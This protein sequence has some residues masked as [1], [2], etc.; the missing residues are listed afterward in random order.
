MWGLPGVSKL[1]RFAA[2][3]E[4]REQSRA[5]ESPA[6]VRDSRLCLRYVG[7]M[8]THRVLVLALLFACDDDVD[9]KLEA[10]A[11]ALLR[12]ADECL[13][14]VTSQHS[15]YDET[16]SCVALSALSAEYIHHQVARGLDKPPPARIELVFTQAQRSAWAAQATSIGGPGLSIW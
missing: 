12:S 5:R 1:Q 6:A 14:T 2:R 11:N 8:H 3:P 16:P 15:K 10:A 7:E 9:P 4:S 13:K